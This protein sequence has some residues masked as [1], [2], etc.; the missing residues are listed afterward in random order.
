M[1]WWIPPLLIAVIGCGS[2]DDRYAG[3]AERVVD[4]QSKH[5]AHA[6]QQ[7]QQI[8]EASRELVAADARSR[9]EM[10]EAH[11]H[12]Q[13]DVGQQRLIVDRQRDALEAER[14][15]IAATRQQAPVVASAIGGAGMLLAMVLPLVLAIF[16]LRY[17]AASPEP[18][19]ELV[20]LLSSELISTETQPRLV[21]QRAEERVTDD[22]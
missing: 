2:P 8:A 18:T 16:L 5:N 22:S 14:R 4:E 9:Q 19:I 13:S 21:E 15:Q 11:E 6:A 20:E 1:K 12:L 17:L 7:T 10:I 3:L